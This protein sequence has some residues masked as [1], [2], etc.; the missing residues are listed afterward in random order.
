[1]QG[2]EEDTKELVLTLHT[3]MCE[4]SE[5]T[6]VEEAH[7]AELVIVAQSDETASL[8]KQLKDEMSADLTAFQ[9]KGL[10][11]KTNHHDLM[12]TETKETVEVAA[13]V[14]AQEKAETLPRPARPPPWR[15]K[16]A[17]IEY[18]RKSKRRCDRGES[19]LWLAASYL[20]HEATIREGVINFMTYFN[21]LERVGTFQNTIPE[22]LRKLCR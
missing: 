6:S 8:L 14:K 1:M 11:R 15:D 20:E 5:V 3:E 10:D 13:A 7:D 19:I 12:K 21:S 16:H 2:G 22:A 17:T 4:K 9:K 18:G